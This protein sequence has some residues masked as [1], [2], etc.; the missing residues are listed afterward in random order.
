MAC[1]KTKRLANTSCPLYRTTSSGLCCYEATV[2]SID[3]AAKVVADAQ[4]NKPD[5]VKKSQFYEL[6]NDRI[7]V[8]LYFKQS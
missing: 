3:D 4:Q 8:Y 2:D 5:Y 1:N 6:P 7:K